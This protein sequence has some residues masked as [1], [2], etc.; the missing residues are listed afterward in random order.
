MKLLKLY[1]TKDFE[2]SADF[3]TSPF[4]DLHKLQDT[5]NQNKIL[6]PN[7]IDEIISGEQS[8]YISMP[9]YRK[10]SPETRKFVRGNRRSLTQLLHLR[11]LI[12][13]IQKIDDMNN[14]YTRIFLNNEKSNEMSQEEKVIVYKKAERIYKEDRR[15]AYR[16]LADFMAEHGD[17]W[18]D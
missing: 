3:G 8:F 15:I 16:N 6:I 2:L 7:I 12:K 9:D 17:C 11:H 14:K 1:F 5:I 18:W 10:L 13:N 4:S